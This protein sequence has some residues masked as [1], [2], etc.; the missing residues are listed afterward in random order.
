MKTVYLLVIDSFGI[1]KAPDA[2]K[3]G[4]QGSDTYRAIAH[5]ADIPNMRALGFD[6]I[7]GVD[8]TGVEAPEGMYGALTETSAGKDTTTGHYELA[9]L[10]VKSPAPT[11]PDGFPDEIVKALCKAFGVPRILGNKAASG[12]EIIK[13]LGDEMTKSG[14]PIVYTSADSVLQIACNVEVVPLDKL[15]GY[16]TAA[17]EIMTGKHNVGRIIA[18]PFTKNANGEYYRTG[19]R[20]DFAAPPFGETMLDRLSARGFEVCSAGKI[21]DIFCGRGITRDLGGHSNDEVFDAVL[22]YKPERDGLVFA[23]FVETD[24]LYGHRN[25]VVGYAECV[26]RFDARLP[27][28][29]A[30][31]GDE[32]IAVITADHGCDPST[33]S[34]D[35][36]RERVPLL[37]FG[38]NVRASDLGQR[39]GFFNVAKLCENYLYDGKIGFDL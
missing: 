33:A 10:V 29:C 38:K 27:E 2:A 22:A 14:C 4:D 18:R 25:D 23:N 32:D 9:G 35:H 30:K 3:Y 26:S 34:T 28:L 37:V 5:I 36:S 20:K 21:N 12:T 8:M 15:Y 31:M 11:Y 39:T 17:R 1:G 6:N 19:D 13:E 16:C 7:V 24:M